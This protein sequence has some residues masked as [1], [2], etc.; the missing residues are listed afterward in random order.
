MGY[1]VPKDTKKGCTP[2]VTLGQKGHLASK[3]RLTVTAPNNALLLRPPVEAKSPESRKLK[4]HGSN[5]LLCVKAGDM[6]KPLPTVVVEA[7][8]EAGL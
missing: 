5:Y 3:R 8:K 6:S 7:K 2:C 1:G 4:A